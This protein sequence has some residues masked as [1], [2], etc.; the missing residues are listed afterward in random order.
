[1]VS[2]SVEAPKRPPRGDFERTER[3]ERWTEAWTPQAPT[4][5]RASRPPWRAGSAHLDH[6]ERSKHTLPYRDT[7][8]SAPLGAGGARLRPGRVAQVA[9]DLA[10]DRGTHQE[11]DD[12]HPAAAL[13]ASKRIHLVD[14]PDQLGPRAPQAPPL[15]GPGLGRLELERDLC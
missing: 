10:H 6:G 12:P 8:V 5:S 15:G 4:S 9:E 7:A 13:G 3:T 11:G 14:A 2:G 1:M